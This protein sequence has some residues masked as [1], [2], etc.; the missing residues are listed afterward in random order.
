MLLRTAQATKKVFGTC[1]SLKNLSCFFT[2]A[3]LRCFKSS[4]KAFAQADR[5]LSFKNM[6]AEIGID[7]LKI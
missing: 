4:V 7:A 5:A 3:I 2:F 6:A 1:S